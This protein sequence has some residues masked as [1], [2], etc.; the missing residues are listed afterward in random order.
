[1]Q[2]LGIVSEM[3]YATGEG[4]SGPLSF[5]PISLPVLPHLPA[6]AHCRGFTRSGQ[7]L[8]AGPD[9]LSLSKELRQGRNRK[10]TQKAGG[11][12]GVT[13]FGEKCTADYFAHVG[14]WSVLFVNNYYFLVCRTFC[15]N[16]SR[17]AIILESTVPVF[18]YLYLNVEEDIDWG[19]ICWMRPSTF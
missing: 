6:V 19:M 1:M 7:L 13:L 2:R 12:S 15:A 10:W 9:L 17:G 16:L 5:K 18:K 8:Q 3:H 11:D 14:K 4:L